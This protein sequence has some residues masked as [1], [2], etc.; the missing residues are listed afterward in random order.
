MPHH[1]TTSPAHNRDPPPPTHNPEPTTPPPL[2]PTVCEY[3][4]NSREADEA[5]LRG[6][7]ADMADMDYEVG[8]RTLHHTITHY[9]TP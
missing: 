8:H 7:G 9:A 1:L 6:D 2:R 5:A 4:N 3:A